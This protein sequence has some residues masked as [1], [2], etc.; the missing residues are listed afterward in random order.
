MSGRRFASALLAAAAL[1]ALAVPA[2]ASASRSQSS[3]FQA[4]GSLLNS[5]EQAQAL[6]QIKSLGADTVRVLVIW[7]NYTPATRPA[8]PTDP[9]AYSN[10]GALD[11]FVRGVQARGMKPYLTI[12][13]PAPGWASQ[14][15]R[16]CAYKDP[17]TCFPNATAFGQFAQAV[18]TRYSGSYNGLPKVSMWS[19]WNEPNLRGWLTPQFIR[20]RGR[21][22]NY[23]AVQYRKLAYAG[24]KALHQTGHGR[25]LLMIPET[26]PIGSTRGIRHRMASPG[27]FLKT[28]FCIDSRGRKLRGRDYRNADCKHLKRFRGSYAFNAIAHHPYNRAASGSPRQRQKR[29]DITIS[30]LSRLRSILR[31]AAHRRLISR[32]VT[33][34][35]YLTEFGFQ[36]NPPDRISG[37][38]LSRQAAYINQS[39][40]I[41][42]R[43]GTVRGVSQYLLEDDSFNAGFQ[44]GLE[45]ANGKKKPAYDAY[46]L[47]I[48]V[49]RKGHGAYVWGQVRPA[50]LLGRQS[51]VIQQKKRGSKKWRKVATVKTGS[52]GYFTRRVRSRSGQFRI[53]WSDGTATF[54]SRRA[55]AARR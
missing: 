24:L 29:D 15:S 38:R 47:P 55:S 54:H 21:T 33:R 23:G 30:T 26:A 32:S 49:V 11:D 28:L 12:T 17:G 25:D 7:R 51:A 3:I 45:F 46:R 19:I 14:K 8:N 6:D 43:D 48:Y 42:W 1:A 13:G 27:I 37:I 10:W 35:I 53:A 22:F 39:D 18:G 34:R 40:Y 52:R 4:D 44:T 41:A 16:V 50:N 5:G 31:D 36:T 20:K 9:A 2:T